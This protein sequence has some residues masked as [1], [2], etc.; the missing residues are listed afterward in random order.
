MTLYVNGV[1]TPPADAGSLD[2]IPADL[3]PAGAGQNGYV[4]T[5]VNATGDLELQP[6]GGGMT[7]P[8]T[9]VGDIIAGSAPIVGGLATPARLAAGSA[10]YILRV[11]GGTPAWRELFDP[12]LLAA[13]PAAAAAREGQWYWVTD[14]AAGLELSL[15]VHKGG[16]TYAWEVVPYGVTAT[17]VTLVQAAN[18]AAART[19]IGVALGTL[20]PIWQRPAPAAVPATT[21]F[22]NTADL[23]E[24]V[25]SGL[26]VSPGVAASGW[27][28]RLPTGLG[29]GRASLSQKQPPNFGAR[30]YAESLDFSAYTIDNVT[31][32]VLFT[33]DGTQPVAYGISEVAM[34]GDRDNE[35]RG[36]HVVYITNGAN[37]DL[38][39]Y[40]NSVYTVLVASANLLLGAAGLHAL[41]VAPVTATGQRWRFSYDGSAVADVAMGAAYVAPNASDAISLGAR[42]DG[43]IFN[44]GSAIE[45]ALW[46]STLSNANILALATLPATPTYELPESASTGAAPVRI[47]ACR[48]DPQ[49]SLTSM[50][51]R[52]ISKPLTVASDYTTKVT[53]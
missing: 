33:W 37:T 2:G 7:N 53:L 51:A 46:G 50:P 15:C 34:V 45:L 43:V 31:L 36:V 1:L 10:G 38:C 39:I 8:M 23:T 30:A 35:A 40:C 42:A 32:A 3:Q 21:S 18:A 12:G 27:M 44:N 20:A 11:A 52:G 6:G 49:N 22:I 14:A 48:Y 29:A 9:A 17:G 13:R 4:V 24:Q 26:V 41:V 5:Y 19:A 16:G 47:Q 25:S 28:Q